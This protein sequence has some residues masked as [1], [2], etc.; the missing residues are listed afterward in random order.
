M[1][2]TPKMYNWNIQYRRDDPNTETI[3]INIVSSTMIGAL[4]KL[5]EHCHLDGDADLLWIQVDRVSEILVSTLGMGVG[6]PA[7]G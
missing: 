2:D 6:P 3:Q 4:Q 1:S 7:C 5:E